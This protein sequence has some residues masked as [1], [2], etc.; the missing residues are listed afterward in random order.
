MTPLT[1]HFFLEEM[2]KSPTATRLGFEEQF[3]PP[4]SIKQNL[5][6]LCENV[7]EPLRVKLGKPITITSGYRCE[8]DNAA[9]GGA[10]NSQHV[11]G[12]AADIL[13]NGMTV[14]EVF[15]FIKAS[16]IP[17]DQNIHEFSEWN[18]I[19]YNPIGAQRQ[20]RLKA[21]KVDGQTKY[22]QA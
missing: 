5:K 12:Q 3:A 6:A 18:H 4:E 22:I 20:E 19:S 7:L 11:L 16:G 21:I 10:N 13:V 2:L 1:E 14:S 17:Y 8:R 9:I 15:D